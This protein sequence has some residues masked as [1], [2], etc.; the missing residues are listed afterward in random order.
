MKSARQD[1]SAAGLRFNHGLCSNR[2]TRPR[3]IGCRR[4]K[5]CDRVSIVSATDPLPTHPRYSIHM[6]DSTSAIA[7]VVDAPHW[8]L[9]LCGLHRVVSTSGECVVLERRDAAM[10]ALLAIEGPTSRARIQALLWPDEAPE[11]VRGR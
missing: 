7:S 11:D 4:R 1:V 3:P 5:G 10:L 2:L 9:H 8:S 6:P